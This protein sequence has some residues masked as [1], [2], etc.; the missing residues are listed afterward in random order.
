VETEKFY[1]RVT[2]DSLTPEVD[3][4]AR[5]E[6]RYKP[7]ETPVLE[8]AKD[9][10]LGR[11][12]L[13]W[14]Q[15]PMLEAETLGP[16]QPG[17]RVHFYDLRFQYPDLERRGGRTLGARVLLDQNLLEVAEWFGSRSQRPDLL[18]TPRDNGK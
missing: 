15:Y 6:T 3:P 18:G 4:A 16:P 7:E 13:D 17:Y 2:V 11:V 1:E 14:A 9:T 10:R 5:S 8:A 12:Y